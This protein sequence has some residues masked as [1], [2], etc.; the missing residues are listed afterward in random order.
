MTVR[1][2][3][4]P[5]FVKLAGERVLVVG[6]G[7]V[8]LRKIRLLLRSGARVEV[9]ARELHAD[10]AALAAGGEL[11]HLGAVFAP[12]QLDGCRAAIAATGDAHLNGEVAAAATARGVPVNVVDSPAASRFIV[13]SIVDRA[14]VLV[15][16]STGG[17][18]PVLARRLRERIEA[19]LP[20]GYG[21]IA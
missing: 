17:A 13:P 7:E 15:A 19:L 8:A 1:W 21:R 16:I 6:G 18:A 4:F 11:R 14:P 20:A 2:P 9:V 10:V 5:M 12:G 3:Y